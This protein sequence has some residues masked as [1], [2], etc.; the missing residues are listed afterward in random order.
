MK[1]SISIKE[2]KVI[3]QMVMLMA[4]MYEMLD[5]VDRLEVKDQMEEINNRLRKDEY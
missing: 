4:K 5:D 1:L 2:T 3:K